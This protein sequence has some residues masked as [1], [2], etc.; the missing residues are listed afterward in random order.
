MSFSLVSQHFISNIIDK[1]IQI[2]G[3]LSSVEKFEKLFI[4]ELI[5]LQYFKMIVLKFSNNKFIGLNTFC[6]YSL[7]N[8]F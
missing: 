3:S 5:I 7:E 8:I 6:P 2:K 4:E 1:D